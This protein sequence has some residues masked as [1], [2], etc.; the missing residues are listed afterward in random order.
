MLKTGMIFEVKN[1]IDASRTAVA[2]GSGG[3]PVAATPYLVLAVENAAYR[4]AQAELSEG[5]ST[6]GTLMNFEH[7]RA[8]PEGMDITARVELAEV[9]GKRL[10]FSFEVHD[11]RELVARGS[12]ERFIVKTEKFLSRAQ[13]KLG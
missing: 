4:L 8:T 10:V 13:G 5:E 1:K 3:Y 11:E 2:L 6:V 7:L 9:D 12:H